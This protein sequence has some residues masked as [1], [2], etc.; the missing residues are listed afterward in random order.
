M[1]PGW[2]SDW[3]GRDPIEQAVEG[4]QCDNCNRMF[5]ANDEGC[6]IGWHRTCGDCCQ[7]AECVEKA[8]AEAGFTKGQRGRPHRQVT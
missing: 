4:V 8:R 5:D 1:T 6:F 7:C 2:D 3:W